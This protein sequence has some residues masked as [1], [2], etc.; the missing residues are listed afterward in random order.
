[1]DD[2]LIMDTQEVATVVS[3]SSPTQPSVIRSGTAQF[4]QDALMNFIDPDSPLAVASA[5]IVSQNPVF[6][7][8]PGYGAQVAPTFHQ[9]LPTLA[10]GVL[11]V[12]GDPAN[13]G[14]GST[15]GDDT[16]VDTDS[17]RGIWTN[18]LDGG[19]VQRNVSPGPISTPLYSKLGLSEADL[20]SVS[21][22][23][24]S[25]APAGRFGN[26]TEVE[27]TVVFPASDE[28]AYIVAS[29]IQ[30]DGGMGNIL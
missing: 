5:H 16:V 1:M 29:E 18:G 4:P 23:I 20:K 24:Q 11:M 21:A 13:R 19:T 2:A 26:P 12:Y 25:Q 22:S 30:I 9:S 27:N 15:I 14:Q 6:S 10:A 8:S 3:Q 17:G 28:S 7:N